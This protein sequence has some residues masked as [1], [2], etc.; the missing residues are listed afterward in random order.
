MAIL[1]RERGAADS[2]CSARTWR[3][4]ARPCALAGWQSLEHRGYPTETAVKTWEK[5]RWKIGERENH[6]ASEIFQLETGV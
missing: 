1:W 6:V 5:N 2:P 4:L 3:S